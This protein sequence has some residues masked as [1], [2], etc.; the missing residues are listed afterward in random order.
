MATDSQ[1]SKWE[2]ADAI[3]TASLNVATGLLQSCF[4]VPW[5][6]AHPFPRPDALPG[7]QSAVQGRC[8][9]AGTP[10]VM[11]AVALWVLAWQRDDHA[12]GWGAPIV[13]LALAGAGDS[14]WRA[15]SQV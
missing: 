14:G 13:A 15:V 6:Y 10:G 2:Y 8:A 3:A 12:G 7:F 5:A 9:V 11:L 1:Q 4:W